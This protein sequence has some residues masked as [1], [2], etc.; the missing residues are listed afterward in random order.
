M[1]ASQRSTRRLRVQVMS[2][3]RVCKGRKRKTPKVH[4]YFSF[5]FFFSTRNSIHSE[6]NT[7]ESTRPPDA[8]SSSP[9]HDAE[10]ATLVDT[11]VLTIQEVR[12]PDQLPEGDK[13]LST[14]IR[15]GT[16]DIGLRT[17]PA[18]TGDQGALLRERAIVIVRSAARTGPPR[19]CAQV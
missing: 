11:G 16:E 19:R 14:Y 6:H 13:K 5:S 15:E 12:G 1:R 4:R 17:L 2:S 18:T 7:M 10:T 3:H 9:A 8:K